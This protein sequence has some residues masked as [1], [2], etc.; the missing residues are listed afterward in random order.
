MEVEPKYWPTS[1][2]TQLKH[3]A[4]PESFSSKQS[5]NKKW[6]TRCN[7][8]SKPNQS[9]SESATDTT[10]QASRISGD[11]ADIPADLTTDDAADNDAAET[12]GSGAGTDALQAYHHAPTREPSHSNSGHDNAGVADDLQIVIR[13]ASSGQVTPVVAPKPQS[14]RIYEA[15]WVS[16]HIS[17]QVEHVRIPDRIPTQEPPHVRRINSVPVLINPRFFIQPSACMSILIVVDR[18]NAK[19][20]PGRIGCGD[21]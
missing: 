19:I 14:I 20:C 16:V 18:V 13:S 2:R 1:R 3:S 15:N 11:T 17:T 10:N 12:G 21:L 6:F 4:T 5:F 9:T 8:C 7:G